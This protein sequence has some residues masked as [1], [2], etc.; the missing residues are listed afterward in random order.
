M[1]DRQR[2][3]A[4]ETLARSEP[5]GSVFLYRY[6][7]G[8]L[9]N[10]SHQTPMPIGAPSSELTGWLRRYIWSSRRST[11]RLRPKNGTSAA[12]G[13]MRE[14]REVQARLVDGQ[15]HLAEQLEHDA[16]ALAHDH[17]QAAAPAPRTGRTASAMKLPKNDD[18]RRRSGSCSCYLPPASCPCAD[19]APAARERLNSASFVLRT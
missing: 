15:P 17:V 3:V 14:P 9:T 7:I 18:R 1:L 11:M 6:A 4:F 16:L 8:S 19:H 10:I 12:N 2:T 13:P 5:T